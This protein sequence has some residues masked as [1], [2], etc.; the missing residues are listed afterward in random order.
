MDTEMVLVV[1]IAGPVVLSI[2]ALRCASDDWLRRF[3]ELAR[4][5]GRPL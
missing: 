4:C 5:L 1:V 3:G 2:A